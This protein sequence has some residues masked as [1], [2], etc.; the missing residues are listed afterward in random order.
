MVKVVS[1]DGEIRMG[2]YTSAS[3]R[4]ECIGEKWE[5]MGLKEGLTIH[6]K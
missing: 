6:G 1:G 5:R 2:F 3:D 4:K